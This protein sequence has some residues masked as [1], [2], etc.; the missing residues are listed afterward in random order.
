MS[1]LKIKD[2]LSWSIWGVDLFYVAR[3]LREE[4]KTNQDPTKTKQW[5]NDAKDDFELKFYA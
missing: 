1:Q 2:V 5:E 3:D 4:K